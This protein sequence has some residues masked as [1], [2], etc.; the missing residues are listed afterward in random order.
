MLGKNLT[1]LVRADG[2]R[3][4]FASGHEKLDGENGVVAGLA[5]DLRARPDLV[6]MLVEMVTS[7]W[8]RFLDR[9]SGDGGTGSW[10]RVSRN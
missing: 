4:R 9:G 8:F 10:N 6:G 3:F 5:P 2:G 7:D 1:L